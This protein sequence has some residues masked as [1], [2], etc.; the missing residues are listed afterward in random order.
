MFMEKRTRRVFTREYKAEAVRLAQTGSTRGT[1]R[2]G[3]GSHGPRSPYSS[4]T[5][6]GNTPDSAKDS[7]SATRP[8]S[9]RRPRQPVLRCQ[10]QGCPR[11][12][13]SGP[14][15]EPQRKLL[16]RQRPQRE[17][18]RHAQAGVDSARPLPGQRRNP[19][20]RLRVPGGLRKPPRAATSR[21]ASSAPMTTRT[22][23]L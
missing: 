19:N 13:G 7:S 1:D 9:P 21:S 4:T 10:I 12:A 15:H 17:R 20:P 3:Q 2:Q 16:G 8:D 22:G 18:L 5:H 6:C 11:R 23:T 14:Q